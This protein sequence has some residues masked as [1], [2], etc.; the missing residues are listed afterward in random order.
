MDPENNITGRAL[1]HDMTLR[2]GW[3]SLMRKGQA[4][5]H[6][7]N[8]T[9]FA[10]SLDGVEAK[11]PNPQSRPC[12]VKIQLKPYHR[13][14]WTEVLNILAREAVFEAALLN[15]EM[16]SLLEP[17][18]LFKQISLYPKESSEW[19]LSCI[20]QSGMPCE[21]IAA[22]LYL[23]G[24]KCRL[25]PLLIFELRGLPPNLLM[26]KIRQTRYINHQTELNKISP[27]TKTAVNPDE[28]PLHEE[29]PKLTY[30][31]PKKNAWLISSVQDPGFWKRDVSLER[32]LGS[33]YQEVSRKASIIAA[34]GT[35]DTPSTDG[36][37]EP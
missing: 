6:Q 4:Y 3:A 32:L 30:T 26:K 16:P 12:Q 1:W 25:N 21:H 8:I 11:V 19:T 24:E 22:A 2:L 14:E 27:A 35:S 28:T 36:D 10:L 34:L 7:H 33:V 18:L 13:E 29:K 31:V 15:H 5:E 20:C 17:G 23:L 9:D 37:V